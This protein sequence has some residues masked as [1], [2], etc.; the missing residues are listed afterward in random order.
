MLP[1]APNGDGCPRGDTQDAVEVGMVATGSGRRRRVP[2][3][4]WTE[5]TLL[6]AIGASVWAASCTVVVQE[7]ALPVPDMT[8]AEYALLDGDA[9]ID[10]SGF[11]RPVLGGD[12]VSCAG[13]EVWLLPDVPYFQWVNNQR[14]DTDT[15]YRAL[16]APSVRPY[17]RQT[18]CDID[19]RFNFR[20]VPQGR[21]LA[22]MVMAWE[23]PDSLVALDY[24][25]GTLAVATFVPVDVAAGSHRTINIT[26]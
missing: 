7:V 4:G 2:L 21:Y 23:V 17:V 19:G 26:P 13:A 6:L 8:E 20:E 18:T 22:G 14:T 16:A 9:S 25:P 11:V 15:V 12:V 5:R 3:A 10:G 1:T 24:P